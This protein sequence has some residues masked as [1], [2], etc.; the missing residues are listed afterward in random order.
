MTKLKECQRRY[1][2]ELPAEDEPHREC[3]EWQT[4]GWKTVP[5]ADSGR[6]LLHQNCCE[7][8]NSREIYED[9]L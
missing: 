7:C 3:T 1:D 6:V 4:I 9:E 2:N 5:S 8:D